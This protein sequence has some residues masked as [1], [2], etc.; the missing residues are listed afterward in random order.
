MKIKGNRDKLEK[1]FF[2]VVNIGGK[3]GRR[4]VEVNYLERNNNCDNILYLNVL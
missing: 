4:L 3:K 2:W 1:G